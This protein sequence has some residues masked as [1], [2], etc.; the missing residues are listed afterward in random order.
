MSL[1]INNIILLNLFLFNFIN[2]CVEDLGICS[3]K[4]N[5]CCYNDRSCVRRK[6]VS[7]TN[8]NDYHIC[9]NDIVIQKYQQCDPLND[10]CGYGLFCSNHTCV[11]CK[12]EGKACNDGECCFGLNCDNKGGQLCTLACTVLRTF[13]FFFFVYYRIEVR[14]RENKIDK[15][16]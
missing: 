15:E 14:E 11:D 10:K 9:I 5:K 13:S 1:S 8:K 2:C 4:Y 7:A 12:K 3:D 6:G 16:Y